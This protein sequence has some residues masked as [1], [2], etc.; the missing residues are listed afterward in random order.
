MTSPPG[1]SSWPRGQNL[2][3][4]SLLHWKIFFLT[5]S[6]TWKPR[7]GV[8]SFVHLSKAGAQLGLSSQ[9]CQLELRE[10]GGSH[11]TVSP[12][13]PVGWKAQLASSSSRLLPP[14][15]CI[16]MINFWSSRSSDNPTFSAWVMMAVKVCQILF[17]FSS[18]FRLE[19]SITFL[20]H[21]SMC[22]YY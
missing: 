2:Y 9:L 14:F 21:N 4:L 16:G 17:G 6:A 10:W 5:T 12:Y 8:D 3:L 19:C 1:G 13:L 11:V 22:R 18:A 20:Q 15:T 7:Q